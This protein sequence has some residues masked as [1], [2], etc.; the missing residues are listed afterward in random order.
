LHRWVPP[1]SSIFAMRKNKI[2]VTGEVR[3]KGTSKEGWSKKEQRK[4][5]KKEMKNN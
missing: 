3:K 4:K 1:V 5:K 2:K